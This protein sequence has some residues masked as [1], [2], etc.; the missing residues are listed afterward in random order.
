VALGRVEGTVIDEDAWLAGHRHGEELLP[1]L[2]GL[3]ARNGLAIGDVEAIIIGTGPGA[4]T[5]LRVGIATAKALAHGL[6]VPIVG[7]STGAALL[8]ADDGPAGSGERGLLLPAGP[9]DRVL[10]FAGEARLLPAGT[11]PDEVPAERLVAVDLVGRADAA[12]LER[13]E[14]A[15]AALGASLIR[16]GADRLARGDVDDLG[17]LVPDYVTLPRGVTRERGEVAWSHGPR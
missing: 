8:A 16:L 10:V 13:G 5:G 6:G 15:I 7:I 9:S 12:A 4:F 17:Q 3:L 11:E 14:R 2:S 1:R